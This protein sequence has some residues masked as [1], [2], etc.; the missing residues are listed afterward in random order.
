M[1]VLCAKCGAEVPV[2]AQFC[3]AC[4]TPVAAAAAPASSGYTPVNIPVQAAPAPQPPS[5]SLPLTG[6][7]PV[8]AAPPPGYVPPPPPPVGVV[9]T[10]GG[11]GGVIKIILIVLAIVVG[12]GILGA[13]AFGFV[14]WRVAHSFHVHGKNGEVTINTPGGSVS[15]SSATAF[16]SDELGTDIYP[17]AQATA[18][19]MRMNLPSGSVVSGVFTTS[20]SKNQVLTFYKNK[21]G[22]EASVFDADESAMVTAKKGDHESVMVTIS[23]KPSENDGKT[24]ISIVHTKTNRP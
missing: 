15:T 8:A 6:Y 17:G 20:D 7:T 9:Q 2:G 22:S 11:G 14:V 19:G 10:S 1:A 18:G 12:L 5:G 4:G 16:T 23:A 24:K 21:F 13:G 3:A